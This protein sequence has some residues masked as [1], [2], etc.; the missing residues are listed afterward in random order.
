VFGNVRRYEPNITV[1]AAVACALAL[2]AGPPS[3]RRAVGLGLVVAFGML[4]DRLSF[5]LFLGL[6][7]LASACWPG[8]DRAARRRACG[9]SAGVAVLGCG[10]YYVHFFTAHFVEIWTQLGGEITS[11]GVEDEA[12]RHPIVSLFY[13]ALTLI[14]CQSGVLPGTA[15]LLG[16]VA[17]AVRGR[18]GVPAIPQ[19]IAATALVAPALVLTMLGK[20]QPFYSIPWLAPLAAVGAAGV[21]SVLGERMRRIV[22]PALAAV[23]LL[24]AITQTR[25]AP[26]AF[27][28][29][30]WSWLA[31]ASP[32]P[33]A[34]LGPT[35]PQ[36]GPPVAT[37]LDLARAAPHSTGE[38]PGAVMFSDAHQAY[39][40]QAMP[41]LRLLLDTREVYGLMMEPEAFAERAA[42]SNCFVYVSGDEARDWPTPTSIDETITPFG[43]DPLSDRQV[44]A[45]AG[46]RSRMTVRDAWPVRDGGRIL[47][48]TPDAPR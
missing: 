12:P 35:F 48:Y 1:A 22:L 40:G 44:A 3:R 30:P 23:S 33:A 28:R 11:A 2:L 10:W 41:T 39:E 37:G 16:V 42:T 13:Y 5:A 6:P 20:K 26:P 8:P 31:G 15:M 36:A 25:G 29:A 17:F 38:N 7:M 21:A 19:V 27:Q 24:Q 45:L 43:Y 46:L 47:V 9:W 4:A 34:L 32:L 18:H 14:D